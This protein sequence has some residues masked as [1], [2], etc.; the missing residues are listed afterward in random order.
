MCLWNARVERCVAPGGRCRHLAAFR[1]GLAGRPP[2]AAGGARAEPRC[3][4][5]CD[6]PE[7]QAAAPPDPQQGPDPR[8]APLAPGESC[9]DARPPEAPLRP[10][11]SSGCGVGKG[12]LKSLS[13]RL[14]AKGG[15]GVRRF[16]YKYEGTRTKGGDC[17]VRQIRTVLVGVYMKQSIL[18]SV[19]RRED[20]DGWQLASASGLSV[21]MAGI[22]RWG[23]GFVSGGG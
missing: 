3:G 2:P 12:V 14:G 8:Q 7:A 6:A 16:G 20:G 11:G 15:C 21:R 17:V 18:H 5:R 9:P 1:G 23:T 22:A 19:Q 13:W 10:E 4:G